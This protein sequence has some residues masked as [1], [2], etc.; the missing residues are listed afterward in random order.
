M[1]IYF[2]PKSENGSTVCKEHH[3][4]RLVEKLCDWDEAGV[5][6]MV[7]DLRNIFLNTSMIANQ[8]LRD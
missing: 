5:A 2:H 3:Y 6:Q 1:E 8:L 7:K 4:A